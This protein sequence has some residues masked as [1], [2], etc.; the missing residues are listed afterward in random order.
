MPHLRRNLRLLPLAALASLVIA[1]LACGRVESLLSPLTPTRWVPTPTAWTPTPRMPTPLVTVPQIQ[2][3]PPACRPGE[4]FYCPGKCPGGCGTICVTPTPKAITPEKPSG[5]PCLI[6]TRTPPPNAPTFVPNGNSL[7]GQRV[8]PHVEICASASTLKVGETFTLIGQVVDIGLPNYAVMLRPAGT[9]DF[10]Q[11]V[12]V[13]Y[14]N[15]IRGQAGAGEVLEVVSTRGTMNQLTLVL[16]ARAAG[17]I[18]V[19]INATGE[20][21]YGYPGPA[22]WAGGG[23]GPLTI[24]VT[25]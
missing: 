8:D 12:A 23:S 19:F 16:R 3:T 4:V 9:D 7:P 15:E 10:R 13:T 2:C 21:H 1:G 24:I 17:T 22:T 20:V 14:N 25:P 11:L 6:V 5:V 18:D